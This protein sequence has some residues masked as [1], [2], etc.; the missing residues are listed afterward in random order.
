MSGLLPNA[1]HVARREYLFRVRGRAFLVTTILL[2]VAVL[3]I[4]MVPTIL[5]AIG[6]ADPPSV[7]VD[8]QADDL[9]TDP[10]VAIQSALILGTDPEADPTE[11]AGGE[12]RPRVMRADDPAE[13]AEGVR[14]GEL[15][16]LLTI[17]RDDDGELAFE[18]LG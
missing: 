4:T 11:P 2:A 18:Y 14:D 16:A 1:F 6:I 15:D 8:V 3:A 5:S 9:S 17:R 10:V 7:A 12:E 13:A